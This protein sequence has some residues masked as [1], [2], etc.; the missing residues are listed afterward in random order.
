[1]S[2]PLLALVASIYLWVAGSYVI[3]GRPGMALAFIAYALANIGFILD[4]RK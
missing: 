3:A 2:A 4:L 1:M